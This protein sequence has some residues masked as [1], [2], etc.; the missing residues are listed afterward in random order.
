MAE[1]IRSRSFPTEHPEVVEILAD[2]RD[3]G[4]AVVSAATR[5]GAPARLRDTWLGGDVDRCLD[6]FMSGAGPGVTVAVGEPAVTVRGRGRGGRNTHAAL[7]AATRIVGTQCVFA[8]IATDGTDG[9]SGAAGGVVDGSIIDRWGDPA[10]ALA[11]S[12]SAGYLGRAG[13]LIETGRTGT[14]VADVWLLWKP[15]EESEPILA[16]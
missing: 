3:A 7:L 12:D 8:A 11:E 1:A 10:R 14:N 6:E 13:S 9:R 15:Y 16:P 5:S 4:R 2:G